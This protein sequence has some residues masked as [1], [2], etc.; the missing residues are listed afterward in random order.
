M[1]DSLTGLGNR[2]YT[3]YLRVR[4]RQR[5]PRALPHRRQQRARLL[6]RS[7]QG[8]RPPRRGG[9]PGGGLLPGTRRPGHGGLRWRTASRRPAAAGSRSRLGTGPSLRAGCRLGDPRPRRFR[10]RS[11][12]PDRGELGQGPLFLRTNPGRAS[13]SG[14]RME[15]PRTP[16]PAGVECEAAGGAPAEKEKPEREHDVAGWLKTFGEK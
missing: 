6:G 3:G 16:V 5:G 12:R 13:P 1:G 15:R 11:A 4:T 2:R 8:R 10:S 14:T 7:P 9:A